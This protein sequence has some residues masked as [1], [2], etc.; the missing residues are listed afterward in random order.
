MDTRTAMNAK[1]ID[2]MLR[3]VVCSEENGCLFVIKPS[4][5]LIRTR[6]MET[7]PNYILGLGQWRP[8]VVKARIS[9][10]KTNSSVQFKFY[11]PN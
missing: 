6:R 9:W 1:H 7:T 4:A 2:L 5:P 10:F 11:C 8:I 3:V